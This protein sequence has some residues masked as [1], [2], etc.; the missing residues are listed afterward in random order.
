MSRLV[1]RHPIRVRDTRFID[2]PPAIV[3]AGKGDARARSQERCF[4]RGA[5][6]GGEDGGV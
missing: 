6:A 3:D 1:I 5:G 2:A 4:F